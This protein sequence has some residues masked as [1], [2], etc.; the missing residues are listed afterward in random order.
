MRHGAGSWTSCCPVSGTLSV[1]EI[2]GDF[3]TC[4]TEMVAVCVGNVQ[5]ELRH[6]KTNKLTCALSK[7]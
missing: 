5:Y 7:D 3:H 6:D 1:S 4:A 2:F